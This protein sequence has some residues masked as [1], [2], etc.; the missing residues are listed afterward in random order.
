MYKIYLSLIFTLLLNCIHAQYAVDWA[1]GI[2]GSGYEKIRAMELDANGNI[3]V[4]G[5]FGSMD[6]DVDPGSEETIIGP[7]GGYDIFIAKYEPSGNLLWVKTLD[8]PGFNTSYDLAVDDQGGVFVTGAF[9][10]TMN[11]NTDGL[12]ELTSGTFSDTFVV[13]FD[14]DGTFDYVFSIHGEGSCA[15][16]AIELDGDGNVY[17]SGILSDASD[18]DPSAE[19]VNLLLDPG[20][21]YLAKY[22][23]EGDYMWAWGVTGTGGTDCKDMAVSSGGDVYLTG[24]FQQEVD[25]DPG[26]GINLY[27]SVDVDS[28]IMKVN[29]EGEHQ[30]ALVFTGNGNDV[31]FATELDNDENIYIAGRYV[32]EIDLD[33]TS[34]EVLASSTDNADAF[35]TKL[36][37]DGNYLWSDS[38]D[39]LGDGVF[40]N[41]DVEES[42]NIVRVTGYGNG[43]FTL[44]DASTVYS[45]G[46][47]D[48]VSLRYNSD[49]SYID[50]LLFGGY[51]DDLIETASTALVNSDPIIGGHYFVSID[52]GPGDIE[53]P[54]PDSQ[55]DEDMFLA[56]FSTT[57][58]IPN[59]DKSAFVVYPNPTQDVLNVELMDNWTTAIAYDLT[60]KESAILNNESGKLSLSGLKAGTYVLEFYMN[61]SPLGRTRVVK[62]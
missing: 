5:Q 47:K 44:P 36:D 9:N 6:L 41:I 43:T 39:N 7:V 54:G 27:N 3:F 22:T 32:S 35:V 18:F 8:G 38:M 29:N 59:F 58:N 17:V 37:S 52:F 13:R 23:A 28:Y 34:G 60:G 10:G 21:F 30:W 2:G 57:D 1:F 19:T 46:G 24:L 11:F 50:H 4:T 26:P 14:A 51:Y 12:Q 55:G 40:N 45:L 62:E 53:F 56:K 61:D 33:P 49:G 42:T 25:F 20:G 15:G 48:I 31:T 16:H